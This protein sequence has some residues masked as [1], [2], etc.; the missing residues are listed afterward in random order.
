MRASK[1]EALLTQKQTTRRA[2]KRRITHRAK[3]T[4][5]H[6]L[7]T[8]SVNDVCACKKQNSTVFREIDAGGSFM[9]SA[10]TPVCKQHMVTMN[11][12]Y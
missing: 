7:P 4:A 9:R 6:K 8:L 10:T 2:K 12:H 5:S 3:T 11:R 1:Q